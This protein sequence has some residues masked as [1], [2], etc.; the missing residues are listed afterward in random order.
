[1]SN[2]INE[3]LTNAYQ[4]LQLIVKN[5]DVLYKY[6]IAEGRLQG[7]R[8]TPLDPAMNQTLFEEAIRYHLDNINKVFKAELIDPTSAGLACDIDQLVQDGRFQDVL[9]TRLFV[10][11][12]TSLKK[13][14][15]DLKQYPH[16]SHITC[17][18]IQG[19]LKEYVEK[20]IE[21]RPDIASLKFSQISSYRRHGD[22]P[23]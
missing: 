18:N 19:S 14:E 16:I 20:L 8:D 23:L 7:E 10:Y 3:K 2:P 21:L 11:R 6:T 15:E 5:K 13:F 1:M 22:P 9:K 12:Q 4:C 17:D